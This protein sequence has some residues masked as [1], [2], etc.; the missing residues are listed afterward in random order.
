MMCGGFGSVKMVDNDDN[1]MRNLVNGVKSH[2]ES[3]LSK[4]IE[5]FEGHSFKSQIVNGTNYTLKVFV[6]DDKYVHVKFHKALECYDGTITIKEV[7][8]NQ[9]IDSSL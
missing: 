5:T 3:H 6:G 1:D 2:V 4:K 9:S 8:E 7:T